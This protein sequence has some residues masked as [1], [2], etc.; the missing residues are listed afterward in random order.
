MT[1]EQIYDTFSGNPDR[2]CI[3]FGCEPTYNL[4]FMRHELISGSASIASLWHTDEAEWEFMKTLGSFIETV[5]NWCDEP[6]QEITDETVPRN[7]G[8]AG[9][10]LPAGTTCTDI[11]KTSAKCGDGK[12]QHPETSTSCPKD[13]DTNFNKED[14]N[15]DGDV[16]LIDL[17]IMVKALGTS[18]YDITGDGLASIDDMIAIIRKL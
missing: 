10:D 16:D 14:I 18:R 9:I 7:T 8:D 11:E 13:C 5:E 17:V 12:C 2:L 3:Y 1:I 4:E 15:R 6:G